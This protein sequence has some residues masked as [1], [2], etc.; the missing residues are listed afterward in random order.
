[1]ARYSEA[2]PVLGNDVRLILEELDVQARADLAG[3]PPDFIPTATAWAAIQFYRACQLSV[4]RD[5][6][7]EKVVQGLGIQCPGTVQPAT[8]Y[9]VDLIFRFLPDL[10]RIASRAAPED[11]L[12]SVLRTWA[13]TWPLSSVGIR[14]EQDFS[15]SAF[16]D[17]SALLR[18]YCD[19]ITAERAT[20][21]TRDLR[22]QTMLQADLGIHDQRF[23][24]LARLLRH[25]VEGTT[26]S[27][28][29]APSA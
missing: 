26:A 5:I 16:A 29:S 8:C 12:I 9:S 4:S 2:M 17:S 11:V 6:A 1:M 7:A 18:L 20:D 10:Y 23:P 22:V 15:I 3:E 24:V 14:L 25:R 21:R 19:R 13:H 28:Q 27:L